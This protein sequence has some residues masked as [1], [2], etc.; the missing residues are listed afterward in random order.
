[1][2]REVKSGLH[3]RTEPR[4]QSALGN[5]NFYVFLLIRVWGHPGPAYL[6]L[7]CRTVRP[8]SPRIMEK[9]MANCPRRLLLVPSVSHAQIL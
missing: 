8:S 5:M 3:L 6:R 2:Q 4:L 9:T 1:M 7:H